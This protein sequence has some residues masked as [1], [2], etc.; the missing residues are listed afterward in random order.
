MMRMEPEELQERAEEGARRQP[1]PALEVREEDHTL[2]PH[3]PRPLLAARQADADVRLPQEAPHRSELG[4]VL[5]VEVLNPSLPLLPPPPRAFSVP[6]PPPPPIRHRP[7]VNRAGRR[8]PPACALLQAATSPARPLQHSP[9]A[10]SPAHPL[11]PDPPLAP[12]ARCYAIRSASPARPHR[13]SRFAYHAASPASPSRCCR[14]YR[15]PSRRV[16]PGATASPNPSRLS[17]PVPSSLCR[18]SPPPRPPTPT[19]SPTQ[20]DSFYYTWK[21]YFSLVFWEYHL[22]DHVDGTVDSSLVPEFHDWSIIDTTIIRWFFL[23]ISPDLF[24]TAVQDGDDA[25]V[26]WTKLNGLFTDNQ[27][28]RHVFLQQEFFGCHQ[29]NTSVDDYCCR[30]KTL[31]DELRD[32]GAKIDDDILLSTLTAGLNEDFDNAAVNLS[33]I[34]NPSLPGSLRTSAWRSGG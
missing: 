17:R 2:L 7:R 12:P 3:G 4:D 15:S 6:P 5:G 20:A 31:A 16:S 14:A 28:Q 27:L 18:P 23:T 25:C 33:L 10:A 8:Y 34:P 32:I 26:V 21:T 19:R 1:E 29:D 11:L 13:Q 30:L 24:Q 22:I 9:A